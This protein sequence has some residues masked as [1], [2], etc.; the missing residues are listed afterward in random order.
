LK[1]EELMK[2]N[3]M[4]R[5]ELAKNSAECNRLKEMAKSMKASLKEKDEAIK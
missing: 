3:T 4:Q 5:A 2:T 1:S